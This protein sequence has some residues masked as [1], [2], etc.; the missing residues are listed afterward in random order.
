MIDKIISRLMRIVLAPLTD[1]EIIWVSLPL[2]GSLVL[3]EIYFG[4]YKK[5]ELGWNSAISNSLL[6]CFVGIDL[7]RR[8]FD[9]NHPYLTFPY[10]RFTIALVIILSGIFLLYLNFYHK[11]PKW[12]AFT[13]SSVIPIN[14]TAYM[15]TV[16]IY[17]SMTI[18]FIT[19][20]SWVL[21]ILIVWG[22]FQ[23]IHSLEPEAWGD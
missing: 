12:L 22:I 7:L 15:A 14:I 18:D 5:E 21:L 1:P 3:I 19:F 17:T 10:A 2:I 20:F 8:I 11:L 13:L 9:K 6:L 4:R 16:V 23:I